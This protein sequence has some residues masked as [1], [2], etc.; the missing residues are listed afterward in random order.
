MTK[1]ELDAALDAYFGGTGGAR[2]ALTAQPVAKQGVISE[3]NGTVEFFDGT[4]FRIDTTQAV[5]K[6]QEER[7][8]VARHI[9]TDQWFVRGGQVGTAQL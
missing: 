7:F 5:D 3:F 1:A 8:V 2:W 9:A 4:G 6:F